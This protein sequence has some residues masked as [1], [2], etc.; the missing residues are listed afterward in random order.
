MFGFSS[1]TDLIAALTAIGGA[2]V[3]ILGSIFG[4]F[5]AMR[6][7]RA[8]SEN[9]KD[10][11]IND[12]RKE[13]AEAEENFRKAILRELEITKTNND[14]LKSSIEELEKKVESIS[15][16]NHRLQIEKISYEARIKF[17]KEEVERKNEEI[18]SLYEEIQKLEDEVEELRNS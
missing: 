6:K 3:T 1:V 15:I 4:F 14:N 5:V 11:S 17:L 13:L 7:I 2:T 16:S 9:T 10:K 18:E 8:E 12:S